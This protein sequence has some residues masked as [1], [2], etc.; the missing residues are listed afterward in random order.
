M[1]A[2]RRLLAA[3]LVLLVAT[4]AWGVDEAALKLLASG[5]FRDKVAAIESMA[6]SPTAR[7]LPVLEAL[8]EGRLRAD[9]Q[10]RGWIDDGQR[11]RDALS[12]DDTALPSPAPAPVTINNRLRGRIGGLLAGL[13]LRSPDRDVRLAAARELRDGVDDRLL[14]A[15]REAVA[16]ER[17]REIQGLLKLAM[18]GAQVRSDDP[19]QRLQGVTALAASDQPATATLLSSLLQTRPDGGFVEADGAVRDAARAAL[20]EVERRLARAE[21]LGQIFAGLSL[22]SILMLAAMGLAVTFGL[23]GVINMAHGEMI[24]IGAY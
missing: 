4:P 2:L 11:V 7:T 12:G 21:F 15:L 16:S 17:D 23:L 1:P 19:A 5:E 14:P 18:A 10:G 9:D 6:T 22:G 20:D 8:L 24:M 13:R 3:C